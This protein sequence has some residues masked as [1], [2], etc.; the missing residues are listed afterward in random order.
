MPDFQP[1]GLVKPN[2]GHWTHY[3]EE[4]PGAIG[5]IIEMRLACRSGT[6][7]EAKILW[8][9]IPDNPTWTATEEVLPL[10]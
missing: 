7:V 2:P 9:D 10:E 6:K 8:N 5:V 4:N 3:N 1:G